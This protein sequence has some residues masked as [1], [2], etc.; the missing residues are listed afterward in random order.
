MF[1]VSVLLSVPN[2]R[3]LLRDV[4]AG[5]AARRNGLAGFTIAPLVRDSA[6]GLTAPT[7]KRAYS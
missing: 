2:H 1:T 7:H 6:A 3:P 4:H 5:D